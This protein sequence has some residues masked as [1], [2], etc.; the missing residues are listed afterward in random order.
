LVLSIFLVSDF[1]FETEISSIFLV[2]EIRDGNGNILR[3]PK[4]GDEKVAGAVFTRISGTTEKQREN[5]GAY[6]RSRTG[7]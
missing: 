6:T 5:H 2:P 1:S 7:N 3:F 4:I